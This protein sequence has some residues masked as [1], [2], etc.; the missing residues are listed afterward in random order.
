MAH[1]S[2]KKFDGFSTCFRQAK[3]D[4]HC[5]YLHGYSLEFHCY[6]AGDLDKCN[7]VVDFGSFKD[8]KEKLKYWFDHTTV[9]DKDDV[10]KNTFK[11]LQDKGLIQLR[12]MNGVGCE[13]FAEFVGKELQQYL[14]ETQG[15][16]IKL[17]KVLCFEHSKNMASYT[18]DETI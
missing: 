13:K 18:P 1:G 16:R 10:H 9:I 7:W 17:E 14:I 8:F 5:K 2:Y 11:E 6:F 3:A 15:S 4:S 12:I